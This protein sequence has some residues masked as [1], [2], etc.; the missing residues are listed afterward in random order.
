MQLEWQV[1]GSKEKL[2]FLKKARDS[3][4]NL[5]GL[6]HYTNVWGKDMGYGVWKVSINYQAGRHVATWRYVKM[7][8]TEAEAAVLFD[9]KVGK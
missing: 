4:G 2:T 3:K 5:F 8:L 9:K 7:E 1:S 6:A